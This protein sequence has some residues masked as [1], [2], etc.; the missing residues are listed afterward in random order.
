[1]Q[2]FGRRAVKAPDLAFIRDVTR[3]A[4]SVAGGAGFVLAGSGAIREHGLTSRPT[5]DV[6]LFAESTLAGKDF[7]A[8]VD[9]TVDAFE[10]R[11]WTVVWVKRGETFV[12]LTVSDVSGRAV[13]VD[14]GVDWR[15]ESPAL[16]SV[17]PV[18]AIE[19]AVGNKVAAAF[20]RAEIRD[21]LDIDSIRRSG[22]FSDEELLALG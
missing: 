15:A 13:G 3:T 10:E 21:L 7:V 9:R 16:L 22:A 5:Y 8:V 17:G 11:G 19:D 20:S 14:F 4:L 2:S 12:Q 6:D 1:M 18:L